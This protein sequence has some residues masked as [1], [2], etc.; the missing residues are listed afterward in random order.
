MVVYNEPMTNKRKALF[1]LIGLISGLTKTTKQHYRIKLIL[2]LL[3]TKSLKKSDEIIVSAGGLRVAN[4]SRKEDLCAGFAPL[5]DDERE[6]LC[7]LLTVILPKTF[8]QEKH[9]DPGLPLSTQ[10]RVCYIKTEA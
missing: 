10:V 6:T 7:A 3:R 1:T 4:A 5:S 8:L 2:S 9:Y